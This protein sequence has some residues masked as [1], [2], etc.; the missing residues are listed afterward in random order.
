MRIIFRLGLV[1][2]F[3]GSSSGLLRA[4]PATQ[5][6]NDKPVIHK[7]ATAGDF[8]RYVEKGPEGILIAPDGKRAFVACSDAGKVVVLDLDSVT[9]TGSVAT[10]NQPDGMAYAR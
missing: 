10:G 2:L 7:I 9:V 8:M 5:P 6:A 1:I 3:L 4:A